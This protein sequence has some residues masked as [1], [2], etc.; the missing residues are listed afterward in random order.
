MVIDF[1]KTTF[2]PKEICACLICSLLSCGTFKLVGENFTPASLISLIVMIERSGIRKVSVKIYSYLIYIFF[3]KIKSHFK[4]ATIEK[5]LKL[6]LSFL[7][8]L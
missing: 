1:W 3:S 2:K 7:T 6:I 5:N 4:M 8:N